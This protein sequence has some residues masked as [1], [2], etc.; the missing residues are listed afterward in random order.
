MA[1]CSQNSQETPNSQGSQ[2][3]KRESMVSA[4]NVKITS[5]DDD[6]VVNLDKCLNASLQIFQGTGSFQE[7]FFPVRVHVRLNRY[8]TKNV[9]TSR[10]AIEVRLYRVI[11]RNWKGGLAQ[12]GRKP[13][14]E[15]DQI[16][17]QTSC[18]QH[19]N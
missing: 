10:G 8:E 11:F 16:H 13:I 17:S 7:K 4:E 3:R 18:Y 5:G 15:N 19:N 9:D 2:K 12:K 14:M 6:V 1:S